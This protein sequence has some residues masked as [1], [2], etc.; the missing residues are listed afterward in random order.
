MRDNRDI[1]S[2]VQVEL[3]NTLFRLMPRAVPAYLLGGPL[4]VLA[5]WRQANHPLLLVWLAALGAVSGL[6]VLT[7]RR[8]ARIEL[9]PELLP[10]W[11][12]I[13]IA[14][15]FLT[16]VVLGASVLMFVD[17]A[18]PTTILVVTG[19]ILATTS[20]GVA[21]L[22]PHLA[23]Y[24]WFAAPSMGTLLVVLLSSP[25]ISVK[26]VG[27]VCVM[28]QVSNSLIGL[29][30]HQAMLKS[31]RLS[32]DNQKLMRA[33]QQAD[34]AKTRFLASA[35]H[36]LRQP[37][38]ALGLFI[39]AL[40][41][42]VRGPQNNPLLDQIDASL[43]NVN[44]MLG[45]LLDVSRLDAGVVK[46][47]LG[48][49]DLQGLFDKLEQEFL[50]MAQENGNRLRFRSTSLQLSTDAGLFE[51]IL[52]NL[53]SNALRYTHHGQVLVAVRKRG[54][55]GVCGIYDNGPGIP[56]EQQMVIFDEFHQ[57]AN[58]ERDRRQGLGLGLAIVRRTADLLEHPLDLK[59]SVGHGSCFFISVPIAAV[60]APTA[61]LDGTAGDAELTG[62]NVLIVDDDTVVVQAMTTLLHS[63]GCRVESC[64]S[65]DGALAL[66][67]QPQGVPDVMLVDYRLRDEVTGD[68]VIAAIHARLGE[69]IPAIII[70]GDTAPERIRE[71]TA[72]GFPLLHKP[73]RPANLRGTLSSL[74]GQAHGQAHDRSSSAAITA[75]EALPATDA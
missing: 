18:D 10:Q 13:A 9:T 53:I 48:T 23:C 16:G 26:F 4:M 41:R 17:H 27:A 5:L 72:A 20:S 61:A 28:T 68:Q 58:P 33:A 49:V 57:L 45:T 7:L 63:W 1:D 38:H 8:F 62:L 34:I 6:R 46:V 25:D 67:V 24:W 39:A 73:V 35:S 59:S 66:V 56:P 36:D 12:R 74:L 30:L 43:N 3:L 37:L 55:R 44:T 52:R 65:L 69:P 54:Q 47:K 70:T 15:T 19:V 31:V 51:R 75:P 60:N 42:K 21:V 64:E 11:S 71:A 29:N 2:M 14:N 32:F 50:P 22:A 40:A